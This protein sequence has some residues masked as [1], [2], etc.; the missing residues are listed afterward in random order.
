MEF[1]RNSQAPR[2]G[3]GRLGRTFGSAGRAEVWAGVPKEL[4]SAPKGRR[5]TVNGRWFN[6]G[7]LVASRLILL[8]HD[9]FSPLG[10]KTANCVLRYR[11]DEVV[12]VLDRAQAGRRVPEVLDYGPD[13]PI[14]A[15]VASA[16]ELEPTELL[17][18][19]APPGGGLPDLFRDEIRTA[20]RAGL[21]VSSGLHVFLGDDP[22]LRGLA[23]EHGGTLRDL[24]RPPEGMEVMPSGRL[25]DPD[26]RILLTVGTD[27][28][29]GKM[30]AAFELVRSG[31]EAGHAMAFAAT[32]Q[33]GVFL[34]DAG[35]AVDRVVADFAA[36]ATEALVVQA[37]EKARARY[38]VVE[39]QGSL[40]HP[41][42][43]GVT[44][45]LLHGARPHA[46]L[47]C[48]HMGR[49]RH[50]HFEDPMPA[51]EDTIAAYERMA[52]LVRP[53]RVVA[54][55]ANGTGLELPAY[56]EAAF[57]LEQRLGLPVVD[58]Y[59]PIG[60]GVRRLLHVCLQALDAGG[61]EA[62]QPDRRPSSR[63]SNNTS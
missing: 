63:E 32:G 34:A 31:R 47:L 29:V 24:R 56:R 3:A 57:A 9:R 38:V 49:T 41:A 42:Y 26:F 39:G 46:L 51:I 15:D 13:V 21:S 17:I 6:N 50:L 48:H 20:L 8:A 16:L 28:D 44:L 30:S 14:V 22:E 60:G 1:R 5:L 37:A 12:A 19:I 25:A 43:S 36:G 7:R 53:A 27:C 55:A 62:F 33:T 40:S 35:C 58:P 4:P 18:G 23:A 10:S 59:T 2:S 52:A 45:S 61:P 54:I 11:G